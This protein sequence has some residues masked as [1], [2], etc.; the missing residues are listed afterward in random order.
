MREASWRTFQH[1]LNAPAGVLLGI[2]LFMW[3][4]SG[5]TL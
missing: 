3:V 5:G 1:A 2:G 4:P